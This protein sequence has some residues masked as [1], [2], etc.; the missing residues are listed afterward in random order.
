MRSQAT[1]K[2]L[3]ATDT[4][5]LR[6]LLLLSIF[7]GEEIGQRIAQARREKGLRQEDLADLLNVSTRTVQ[8]YELGETSQYRRLQTIS[9]ILDRPVEWFLHGDKNG[10]SAEADEFSQLRSDVAELRELVERILAFL[11]HAAEPPA[12]AGRP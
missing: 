11:P 6:K 7:E 9:Q 5:N 1:R 3:S 4:R 2:N 10:D 8:G 12:G